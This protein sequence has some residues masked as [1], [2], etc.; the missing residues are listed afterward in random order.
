M[1][2]KFITFEGPEK[3]GK[4][5]Q[6]KLLKKYLSKKGFSCL[7]I[8]E[9]GSTTLGEKIRKI[10][11]DKR[12]THITHTAEMLLY[13]AAR[14]QIINKIIEPALKKGQIVICDRFLD[15]TIVYQGYGLGM[16]ISLIKEIGEFVTRGIKPDITILLDLGAKESLFKENHK[17]DRIE[18]RSRG[19]H[20]KVRKGYLALAE[21]YPR[22]IKIVCVQ[23]NVFSTQKEIRKVV[24]KCLLKK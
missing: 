10:L 12:N 5:T 13:M 22:R 21:K 15:S 7:F 24:D 9:P 8:R 6:A 11:L 4:S 3:S 23:D 1:K 14:A 19:Y 18:L 16:D 20:N 2:G 17:K